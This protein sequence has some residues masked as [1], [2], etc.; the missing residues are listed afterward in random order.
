MKFT[1]SHDLY[2]HNLSMIRWYASFVGLDIMEPNYRPNVLTFAAGFGSSM[3]LVGEFYTVWYFWP[4][5]V[6]I[7][8]SAAM[9][10]VIIQGVV[11][12]YTAVRY[13][14][15][16]EVMYN[17]LDL[18]HYEC[19]Q[20]E[21]NN[22]TLL[23][24]M[25]RIC[26]LRQYLT[27]QFCI[28]LAI[29]VF[30]PAVVY[31]FKNDTV[32]IFTILIPF[33]DPEKTSHYW[34]NLSLQLYLVVIGTAGFIAAESV[35]ILF[36]TSVAGY[37]NVLKN[38]INEMNSLLLNAE[39]T[40]D[41]HVVKA[42]LLEILLLHQ[43]VLEYEQDLEQRYYLNNWVQVASI[44]INLTGALFGCYVNGSFTM[45]SIGIAVTVQLFE[46]CLLGTILSIKNEEI[47]H[48][49]YNSLWYLM[50]RSERRIFQ[51]MFHKSQH[52]VEMTVASMAPLNIVLFISI[53]RKIY[54]FAM[55]LMSFFE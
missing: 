26:L 28:T 18:F 8:E 20:H 44:V 51:I 43:R 40:G 5:L 17:R 45:F 37:A 36:V 14:K 33:T 24:L 4:N 25:E 32:L 31:F 50:D 38:E 49:F 53:M 42:K 52:A 9:Y 39:H 11:K 55:M 22:A 19:R 48:A 3:L 41:R 27:L 29:L 54:A 10:G 6:K 21:Q 7:M 16:F 2:V 30:T 46:L 35:L 47:E 34:I 12:F 23:K 15:F 1:L 13:R